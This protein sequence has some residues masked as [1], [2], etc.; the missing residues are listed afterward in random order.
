MNIIKYLNANKNK[1]FVI[2]I[3]TIFS[4][5][6]DLFSEVRFIVKCII[7]FFVVDPIDIYYTRIFSTGE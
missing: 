3:Y 1:N 6:Y 7:I 4:K 5:F 2:T